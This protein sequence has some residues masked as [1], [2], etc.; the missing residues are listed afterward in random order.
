M[1]FPTQHFKSLVQRVN[2]GKHKGAQIGY[3]IVND[4]E[5]ASW[6]F[7]LSNIKVDSSISRALDTYMYYAK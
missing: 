2:F 5:Y 3:V 1:P 6:L 4:P 7:A